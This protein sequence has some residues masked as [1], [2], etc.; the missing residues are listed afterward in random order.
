MMDLK[1]PPQT[2]TL[3]P[4]TR[5]RRPK[6][7][8][9][10]NKDTNQKKITLFLRKKSEGKEDDEENEKTQVKKEKKETSEE[11]KEEP[12]PKIRPEGGAN[13]NPNLSKLKFV[14]QKEDLKTFLARK[15]L[16]RENRNRCRDIYLQPLI[17]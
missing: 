13:T 10:P 14:L 17:G 7:T 11:N 2:K 8:P 16:E 6:F 1:P 3:T 9:K 12:H 5:Q 15:K 4:K